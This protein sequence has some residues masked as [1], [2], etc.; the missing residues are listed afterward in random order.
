MSTL[1]D[2]LSHP[3]CIHGR[4]RCLKKLIHYDDHTKEK[5]QGEDM[6]ASIIWKI[7][8]YCNGPCVFEK[9][10]Q[11]FF[12][13]AGFGFCCIQIHVICGVL[14]IQLVGEFMPILLQYAPDM[15]VEHDA[16]YCP[17]NV[18]DISF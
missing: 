15:F 13:S 4:R 5:W 7:A 16:A 11:R 1:N 9:F 14:L 3:T 12:C 10:L 8:V 2:F 6:P 18:Q 17:Q